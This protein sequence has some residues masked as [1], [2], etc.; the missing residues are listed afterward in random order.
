MDD[1]DPPLDGVTFDWDNFTRNVDHQV[2]Y[3]C[4][5]PNKKL[6]M[7]RNNSLTVNATIDGWVPILNRSL[8]ICEFSKCSVS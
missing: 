7:N 2:T 1:P 6:L 5:D 4:D 3:K 8:M